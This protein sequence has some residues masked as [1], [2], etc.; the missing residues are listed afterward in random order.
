MNK[1]LLIVLAVGASLV[2]LFLGLWW[3]RQQSRLA[4]FDGYIQTA[5]TAWD[6]NDCRTIWQTI[7]KARDFSDVGEIP[8]H[9]NGI[10]PHC[11][12]LFV[13]IIPKTGQEPVGDTL[14]RYLDL[15]QKMERYS[16]SE[17]IVAKMK[18]VVAPQIQQLFETTP[19]AQLANEG[20]CVRLF[21]LRD[22]NLLPDPQTNVPVLYDTCA[23]VFFDVE[24]YGEAAALYQTLMDEY[25]TH[26]LSKNA[27]ENQEKAWARVTQ[28]PMENAGTGLQFL[29]L[30]GSGNATII[31]QND[32]Y[33]EILV[34]LNGLYIQQVTVKQ[35]DIC[36][37]HNYT[38]ENKC[39]GPV[40][41]LEVPPGDYNVT[42]HAYNM[43]NYENT[44]RLQKGASYYVC[45]SYSVFQPLFTPGVP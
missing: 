3:A 17:K 22:H 18:E 14:V 31:I 34:K 21:E 38:T 26:E 37:K 45:F 41:I 6:N 1:K 19:A 2:M 4:Q 28:S 39:V 24:R 33:L 5:Q 29:N 36:E 13:E 25:P 16:Q 7:P 8:R 42:A 40:T 9:L 20:M 15:L 23:S 43:T 44:W 11:G 32:T 27:R 30:E 35:C 12:A 10:Q